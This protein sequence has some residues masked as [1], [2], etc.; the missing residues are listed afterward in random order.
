M[1]IAL[2]ALLGVIAPL[3]SAIFRLTPRA[4]E[5]LQWP[6]LATLHVAFAICWTAWMIWAEGYRGFQGSFAPRVAARS[7]YLARDTSERTLT[8][9][10]LAPAYAIGL[11]N[12]RKRTMITAWVVLLM[13][14]LLVLAVSALD[15]PWRGLID[16]GVV[17]G[18]AY[19]A[20][21][22]LWFGVRAARDPDGMS[23]WLALPD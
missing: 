8:S 12:A 3:A 22:I 15:Q 16:L 14:I 13:I 2:W 17:T 21:S 4:V 9:V 11:F 20:G 19:G 10:I 7:W 1:F 23:Q 18:L 6:E 5:A